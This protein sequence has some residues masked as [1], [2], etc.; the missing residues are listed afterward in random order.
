[1][2]L[3]A[4][5]LTLVL[6][7]SFW[8]SHRVQGSEEMKGDEPQECQLALRVLAYDDEIVAGERAFPS[9]GLS[10]FRYNLYD[11]ERPRK[12]QNDS[13]EDENDVDDE[14]I[15][16]Y[17]GASHSVGRNDCVGTGSFN[18]DYKPET[19]SYDSQIYVSVSCSGS[20]N[21]I[22]GGTGKYAFLKNGYEIILDSQDIPGASISELNFVS[23]S[24]SSAQQA[25]MMQMM[26]Q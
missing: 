23:E 13:G 20:Y 24:C 15:G 17:I 10:T 5:V 7:V 14:P 12:E 3:L 26:K 18:F 9:A 1:M 22:I 16:I 4:K 2:L 11:P 6:A 25:A 8:S 21:A 19:D